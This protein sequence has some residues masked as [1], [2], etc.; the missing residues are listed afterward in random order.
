MPGRKRRPTRLKI[1]T[2]NPGRRPLPDSEPEPPEGNVERPAFL[3]YRAAEIWDERAQIFIT[4]GT[5]T[6]AD[7]DNFAAW[8][9]LM[10][11]FEQSQEKMQAS[12]IAQMRMLAADFGMG[13]SARAKLGTGGKKQTDPSDQFFSAG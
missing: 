8:C 13:A 4:M 9:V 11:E 7:V 3:K 5:L 6:V 2:G 1:V 12:M 10:A